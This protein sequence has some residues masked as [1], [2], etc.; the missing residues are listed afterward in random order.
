MLRTSK[1]RIGKLRIEYGIDF[2]K[3]NGR[4]SRTIFKIS[5][6]DFSLTVKQVVRR[7]PFK[8]ISTRKYYTGAHGVAIILNGEEVASGTFELVM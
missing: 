7:H 8:P 6:S 1:D 5:E 4:L 2:M 3:S